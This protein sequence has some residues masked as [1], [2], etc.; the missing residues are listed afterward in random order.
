M[1]YWLI[2]TAALLSL[3]ASSF[4]YSQSRYTFEIQPDKKVIYVDSLK[5]P[6][7]TF[8]KDVLDIIPELLER[9]GDVLFP[10][11]DVQYDG[12]SVGASR[13]VFLLE[14]RLYQ[15]EKMIQKM[16]KYKDLVNQ[17]FQNMKFHIMP[18]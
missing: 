2:V 16:L 18:I 8:V 10:N 7:N 1:K 6:K 5:F 9:E 13:D 12:K 11:Y 15:L 4:S 14:T 3:A 17:L